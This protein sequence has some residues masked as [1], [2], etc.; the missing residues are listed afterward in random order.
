MANLFNKTF[1][2][3]DVAHHFKHD[4]IN[5]SEAKFDNYMHK[6]IIQFVNCRLLK[7]NELVRDDLWIRNGVIL[8]PRVVFFDEKTQAD[9]QID[10]ED[11]IIAP[12]LID[13]QL[14]GGFGKDFTNQTDQISHNLDYVSTRLLEYG[15]T[16][17][18]PTI[19]SSDKSTYQKLLPNI[20]RT[21]DTSPTE[22]KS[23]ILGVHLEGPFINKENLGAHDKDVLQELTNG[24]RTLEEIYGMSLNDLKKRVSIITLAPELD[25][26][27][28]VIREL[29]KNNIVV[30]IGHSSANLAQGEAA[31]QNGARFITHLFNAMLPFHHRDPHLVG[32][33][34]NKNFVKQDHV[35]YGVIADAIH[36]H[37]SAINI[38]YK[39][40][41]NGLVL[42]TDAMSAMGL[43]DGKAH[44][45][46]NKL[47]EIVSDPTNKKK[48]SAFI[49]GTNT[50]C[51]SV[52][53][54]DECVRNLI[55]ATGCSL[56]EAV[57]CATEHPAKLLG[58]YP[59]KGSLN[60][61]ADADFIFIDENVNVKATFIN[62]DLAWSQP[63]WSP[64]FK[65]KY[66]P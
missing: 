20:E 18:C 14:N 42:V 15:V 37:P 60:Y 13:V 19:V 43:E 5:A 12:G 30:S 21:K 46:G 10:C 16:A 41:P 32:L 26:N 61:G 31:I 47:V 52:V 24:V 49:K 48:R 65:Y 54:M 11:L 22:H 50:L 2:L 56:V 6:L 38:S 55:S 45:L 44:Q 7:D 36:T 64:L 9:V 3:D 27:C 51:G 66:I 59:K 8:N 29:N 34:S 28:E 40:H 63:D 17:Y 25:K 35:Y 57:K 33:L 23:S 53:T 1:N 39:S 58:I 4:T 62:G